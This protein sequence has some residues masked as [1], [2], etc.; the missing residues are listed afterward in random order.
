[1]EQVVGLVVDSTVRTENDEIIK[2]QILTASD[3]FVK[4]YTLLSSDVEDGLTRVRIKAKIERKSLVEKLEAKQV[5]VTKVNMNNL[6]AKVV[7]DNQSVEDAT[8]LVAER[9]KEFHKVWAAEA[10]EPAYDRNTGTLRIPLTISADTSAYSASTAR[11]AEVLDKISIRKSHKLLTSI[12]S[13]EKDGEPIPSTKLAYFTSGL[14]NSSNIQSFQQQVDIKG[15]NYKAT[16]WLKA[17]EFDQL[18][19]DAFWIWLCISEKN[20]TTE[21]VGYAIDA[22]IDKIGPLLFPEWSISVILR[23]ENEIVIGSYE[24]NKL[25]FE[26]RFWVV[27]TCDPWSDGDAHSQMGMHPHLV[28]MGDSRYN[29]S[30][31]GRRLKLRENKTSSKDS[32]FVFPEEDLRFQCLIAPHFMTVGSSFDLDFYYPSFAYWKQEVV[33]ATFP[34][35]I[36][37]IKDIHKTEIAITANPRTIKDK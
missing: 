2:D 26:S 25:D 14:E 8:L 27:D 28:S 34:I 19:K 31:M 11:L 37:E 13:N 6:F 23:D 24:L 22:D 16:E 9:I 10:G 20:F 5:V 12:E 35:S 3:G 18:P 1:V 36:D 29:R 32:P 21:W 4:V 30:G 15:Q 17:E 7:S 33:E